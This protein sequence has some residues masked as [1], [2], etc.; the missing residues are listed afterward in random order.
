MLEIK[1]M[2]WIFQKTHLSFSHISNYHLLL[3]NTISYFITTINNMQY[4]IKKQSKTKKDLNKL[5]SFKV[6]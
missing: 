4:Y 2:T 1:K 3:S 6:F 5:Y